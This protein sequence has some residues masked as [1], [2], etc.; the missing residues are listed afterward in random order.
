MAMEETKKT[1]VV[2][3]GGGCA[4]MVAAWGILNSKRARDFEI[5]I[6]QY[7][8]RLG[9]KCA[10]GRNAAHGQRIEEHGLHIWGGMYENAFAIMR[11]VYDSL[12]RDKNLPLSTWYAADSPATSAF[13]P[14]D[15]VSLSEFYEGA[16]S[17]WNLTM[18][19]K[20]GLPGDGQ[21]VPTLADVLEEMFELLLELVAGADFLAELEGDDNEPGESPGCVQRL[22]GLFESVSSGVHTELIRHVERAHSAFSKLS[23]LV[24]FA[25]AEI[26]AVTGPLT[27]ALHALFTSHGHLLERH[28]GIRHLYQF[29]DFGGAL[30]RGIFEDRLLSRGLDAVDGEDF[31]AWLGR[32]GATDLTRQG[33]LVR[34]WYGFFFANE[35]GDPAEPR[36]SASAAL[37]TLI[38]Y[39]F[40]YSGAFFWKMQAGM[41]DTVFA[42]L[43]QWLE[44]RGVKFAFFQRVE[45][46]ENDLDGAA[47]ASIESL[48]VTRQVDLKDGPL[49][50]RPLVTVKDVPCWP[51][52][53]LWD[54]IDP[55]QAARLQADGV[56]LE[57][58][59]A[60]YEPA[61]RCV[62]RRGRDFDLV[63][64]AI[65]PS[66]AAPI[67]TALARFHAPWA[68]T[69]QHLKTIQTIAMQVWLTRS[70]PETGWAHPPTVGTAYAEPHNTWANMDQLLAR[71]EWQGKGFVP[72]SVLYFCG[73]LTDAQVIPEPP[74]PAF[75]DAQTARAR[76]L[77]INW[78]SSQVGPIWPK[79]QLGATPGI[80]WSL[81]GA[82]ASV[83]Q[84]RF[85]SQY[86]RLNI[87]PGERYVL[88]L[89]GTARFRP[90]AHETGFENLYFA[91]D[92][93]KT[94]VDAGC[95]EAAV[96][97]GLQASRAIS[98]F[99][100]TI[101]GEDL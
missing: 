42:P 95:V 76:D 31:A 69:L 83:G 50:Y 96:M 84:A 22:L 58:F 54:Q 18:P 72:R 64:L 56:N 46:I 81:M 15:Y 91:G 61:E 1:R 53:P 82:E 97:G 67:T 41:G 26:D 36:L 71:E 60:K 85:D 10:S 99:P 93:L 16:W 29:L 11:D 25:Q 4:G 101:I 98:G 92:W 55:E 47:V 44:Q 14:H 51:S 45:A 87:D 52:E 68:E 75:A 39:V 73:T 19:R 94:G 35:D 79:L 3:V 59:W 37:R 24:E 48:Q 5:T 27:S 74:N 32:H 30:L 49:S 7:G 23:G 2:I 28:A 20:N 80:D 100:Q 8:W 34:G 88:S 21:L 43:Y 6:Y 78:L 40:S 57:S 12:A 77:S 33:A 62:L 66:A 13:W 65:P 86:V 70:M 38:R 89:P 90:R 17:T 63:V 9:G